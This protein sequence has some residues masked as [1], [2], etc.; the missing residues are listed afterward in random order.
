MDDSFPKLDRAHTVCG[1]RLVETTPEV[2][3][4]VAESAMLLSQASHP[5]A[6]LSIKPGEV[7]SALAERQAAW[8]C[9]V[10]SQ[11]PILLTQLLESP[12]YG[13]SP[14]RPPL[15]EK[16]GV[17]LFVDAEDAPLYVGRVGLTDRSR[18]AGKRFS[19]FRTRIR[20]HGSVV[21]TV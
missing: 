9:E 14:D 3:R 10:T 6:H 19:S 21:G 11:L 4:E 13:L 8:T 2:N 20:A 5:S 16:Y 17:Y 15:P 12:I 7:Q 1:G 18:L